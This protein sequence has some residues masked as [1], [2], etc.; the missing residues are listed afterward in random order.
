MLSGLV[1][2]R[3]ELAGQI[4]HMQMELRKL[5]TDLDTIDAAIR[6]FDPTVCFGVQL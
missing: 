5:V 4:E 3:A 1:C 2:K 6:I